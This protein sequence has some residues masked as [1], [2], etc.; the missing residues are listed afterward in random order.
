MIASIVITLC[1]TGNNYRCPGL[2]GNG[3][4]RDGGAPH[5][6]IWSQRARGGGVCF[7]FA[8]ADADNSAAGALAVRYRYVERRGSWTWPF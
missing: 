8:K 3:E 7:A 2:C 4:T 6:F 1:E 5:T